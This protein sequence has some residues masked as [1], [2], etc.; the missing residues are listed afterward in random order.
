MLSPKQ[1][2][3]QQ[4]N[5]NTYYYSISNSAALLSV[6]ASS[7]QLIS[8][9]GRNHMGMGMCVCVCE[10]SGLC[11]RCGCAVHIYM[12]R[13][14][15]GHTHTRHLV[16][17]LL[18]VPRDTQDPPCRLC[19]WHST[20]V[21][22]C[23]ACTIFLW[24]LQNNLRCAYTQVDSCAL[25]RGPGWWSRDHHK[26]RKSD[27]CDFIECPQDMMLLASPHSWL[28]EAVV[29]ACFCLLVCFVQ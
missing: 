24:V 28:E 15:H 16:D 29:L 3:Q 23:T 21:G 2:L 18:S 17:S 13:A 12:S 4:P 6:A 9:P 1:P 26:T 8:V 10:R 5:S 27:A 7:R 19:C 20:S 11:L 25:G 14:H 22:A